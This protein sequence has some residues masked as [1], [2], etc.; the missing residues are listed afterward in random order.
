MTVPAAS[1]RLTPPCPWCDG[2]CYLSIV[3]EMQTGPGLNVSLLDREHGQ[4][5]PVGNLLIAKGS[6][7]KAGKW[8]ANAPARPYGWRVDQD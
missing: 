1:P 5:C 4:G 7:E 2:E 6:R 3:H 8:W